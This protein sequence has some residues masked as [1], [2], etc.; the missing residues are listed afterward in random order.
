MPGCEDGDVSADLTDRYGSPRPWVRSALVATSVLVV[1]GF[2]GWL[3][4]ATW[5]FATPEIESELLSWD[6][7]SEHEAVATVD[8]RYRDRDVDGTCTLRAFAEDHTVVG[9]LTFPMPTPG[10]E[11]QEPVQRSIR[12]ERR[13][14]SVELLGCTTPTQPRPR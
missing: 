14:T 1:A 12:T 2:L 9:E 8:V 13:A 11:E 3:A 10:V 6:V 4:W 7:V 5:F